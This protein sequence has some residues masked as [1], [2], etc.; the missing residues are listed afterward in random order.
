MKL[1]ILRNIEVL[2]INIES[3]PLIRTA[4]EVVTNNNMLR[5]IEPEALLFLIFKTLF[6]FIVS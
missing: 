3:V 4:I 5:A 1:V 6:N 2:Q